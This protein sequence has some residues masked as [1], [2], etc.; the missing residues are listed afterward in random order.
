MD[1]FREQGNRLV[2]IAFVQR[3][4]AGVEG[5]LACKCYFDG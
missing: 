1:I 3:N 2:E 5:S 4:A